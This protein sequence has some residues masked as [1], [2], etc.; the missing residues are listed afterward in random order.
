MLGTWVSETRVG[1]GQ[2][3]AVWWVG[4]GLGLGEARVLSGCRSGVARAGWVWEDGRQSVLNRDLIGEMLPPSAV[5][6]IHTS[7]L[8]LKNIYKDRACIDSMSCV[9]APQI[10]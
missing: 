3:D 7:E 8:G 5:V 1:G 10:H 4:V 9:P 6:N 2:G